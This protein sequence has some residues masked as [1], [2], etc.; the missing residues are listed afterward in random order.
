MKLFC[1]AC[2]YQETIFSRNSFSRHVHTHNTHTQAQTHTWWGPVLTE[3]TVG[4]KFYLFF[5]IY[6][7]TSTCLSWCVQNESKSRPEKVSDP[8]IWSYRWV[9]IRLLWVLGADLESFARAVN[10]LNCWAISS[11]SCIVLH[12]EKAGNLGVVSKG[13]F[14]W[15]NTV[16]T[17]SGLLADD[18]LCFESCHC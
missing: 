12:V 5:F 18:R 9:L 6:M 7:Y 17:A 16:D 10:A 4:V 11:P 1:L 2:L 13:S 3:M 14:Q 8:W 15:A